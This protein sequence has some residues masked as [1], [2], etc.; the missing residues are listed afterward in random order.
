MRRL[1][2]YLTPAW[3]LVVACEW[4][5]SQ[6][7][8]ETIRMD[9]ETIHTVAPQARFTKVRD[10]VLDSGTVW[11]LDGTPPFLAKVTEDGE[12]LRFGGKGRGPGELLNPGAI[13]P[14]DGPMG[15][16]IRAWDLA[17]N[18]VSTFDGDGVFQG[19]ERLSDEGLIRARSNIEEVSYIDP[20]RIR[21][22]GD[23]VVVGHFAARIDRTAD[24][25]NGILRYAD[26]RLNPGRKILRFVDHM[27]QGPASLREWAAVP[28]WD[29]CEGILV[30]WSPRRGELLWL[31]PSGSELGMVPVEGTEVAVTRLDVER[32]L[33]WM[34]RLELGP[35]HGSQGVDYPRMAG[36]VQDRFAESHPGPVSL[37]C[38]SVQ[39]AWLR[40]FDTATDPLGR[41]ST[42]VRI[43]CGSAQ[44][45]YR[46]P[47]EFHPVAFTRG[48]AYGVREASEGYQLLAWW[49]RETPVAGRPPVS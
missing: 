10:I 30:V 44:K 16:G 45:R 41:G 38:E 22:L 36:R 18:R 12:V 40:L 25:M 42:W 39:A 17:L 4:M 47:E 43:S 35:D 46:F 11:V 19:S 3:L 20:F 2:V 13:R 5:A 21:T 26:P 32:Y 27:E 1:L 49:E 7:L 31:D 28:L 23:S 9:L 48:G 37:R 29:V 6:P 8:D 34:G 15:R 33:R 24:F 14:W